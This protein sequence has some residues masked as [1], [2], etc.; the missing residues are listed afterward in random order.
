MN[1]RI[2]TYEDLMEYKS[3]LHT[4]LN[5]QK[6]L[7]YEDIQDIKEELTPVRI[8]AE[9]ISHF[10]V[11][12]KDHSLLVK[13]TNSVIDMLLRN[14]FL[15]K[16]GWIIKAVVPFLVHNFSSHLVSGNKQGIAKKVV[17]W[18]WRKK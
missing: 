3:N 1:E 12:S 18:L 5:I 2:R 15:R 16:S 17:S 10:F 6:E 11:P 4:Q 14:V 7:I 13:G 8:A 9:Q